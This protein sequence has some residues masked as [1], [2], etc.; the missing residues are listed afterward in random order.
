MIIYLEENEAIFIKINNFNCYGKAG[1][2]L[3]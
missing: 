2:L 3:A 1:I